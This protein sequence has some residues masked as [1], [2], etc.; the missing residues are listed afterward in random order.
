MTLILKGSDLELVNAMC[1]GSLAYETNNS[2]YWLVA[3]DTLDA[4]Y[5][6]NETLDTFT[7]GAG[8][9]ANFPVM[10]TTGLSK[11]QFRDALFA[12]LD[13]HKTTA[14]LATMDPDV[15]VP[16]GKKLSDLNPVING[17]HASF[18]RKIND[19]VEGMLPADTQIV[20]AGAGMTRNQL[21]TALR[22]AAEAGF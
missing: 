3:S 22:D 2:I 10:M 8:G 20:M 19:F 21:R 18:G 7:G 14:N 12:V 6:Y 11:F 17:V 4:I 1:I 9:G 16:V 15:I 5:E 13:Q